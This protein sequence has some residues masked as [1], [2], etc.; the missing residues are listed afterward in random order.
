MAGTSP[1]ASRVGHD[2]SNKVRES[3]EKVAIEDIQFM[4]TDNRQIG[5]GYCPD[6]DAGGFTVI[7][8]MPDSFIEPAAQRLLARAAKP[9]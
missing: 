5:V 8:W 4:Q 9:E 3:M 2:Y 7:K 6:K 1:D